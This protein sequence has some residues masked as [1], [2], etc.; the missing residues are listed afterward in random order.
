MGLWN[1]PRQVRPVAGAIRWPR[2][3]LGT[4]LEGRPFA[5][6]Y[7]PEAESPG[8]YACGVIV[9]E[10]K[11]SGFEE[12]MHVQYEDSAVGEVLAIVATMTYD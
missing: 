12:S 8:I 2:S 4:T 1:H 6:F 7:V 5:L 11:V 9:I 3:E 10:S